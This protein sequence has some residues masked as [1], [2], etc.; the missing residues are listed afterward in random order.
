MEFDKMVEEFDTEGLT[1]K[2][3]TNK[4]IKENFDVT[5]REVEKVTIA[6]QVPVADLFMGQKMPLNVYLAYIIGKLEKEGVTHIETIRAP[7]G[8]AFRLLSQST[9]ELSEKDIINGLKEALK[10]RL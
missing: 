8:P 6:G 7:S 3:I 4:F 1:K 5:P 9:I 2:K 10:A